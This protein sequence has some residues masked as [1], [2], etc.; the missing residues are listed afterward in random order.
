MR[1]NGTEIPLEFVSNNGLPSQGSDFADVSS[2]AGKT[3]TLEIKATGITSFP[4][5]GYTF[6][7]NFAFSSSPV[8][9]IPEPCT[10]ALSM[11]GAVLVAFHWRFRR[12]S[13]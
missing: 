4:P 5:P 6:L 2:F 13:R 12:D 7:D 10:L 11:V 1:F 9:I 3:G 8:P